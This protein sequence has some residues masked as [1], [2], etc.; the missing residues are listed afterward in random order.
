MRETGITYPDITLLPALAR[1][2]KTDL[3]TLMSFH[4]DLTDIEIENFTGEVDRTVRE[5]GYDV[6]FQM[7]IEKLHEYPTCEKLLY[8]VTFYL[9]SAL[10][11][12]CVSEKEHYKQILEGFYLRMAKSKTAEIRDSALSMLIAYNR[13]REDFSKA[14]EYIK[15]L[16]FST[17]NREEQLAV[18]YTQQEKY[19]K[20]KKMWEYRVLSGVKE[21]QTAL[22]NM[23]DI[24]IKEKRYDDAAFYADK[25]EE[26][27]KQF[28]IAKWIAYT[29]H[30]Q[31]AVEHQD[32]Q[33][34][35]SIL[36]KML[37]AMKEKWKLEESPLYQDMNSND[38]TIFSSQLSK[39]MQNDLING[40]DFAFIREN[41]EFDTF[42]AEW[43]TEKSE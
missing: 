12:Y 30:L 22:M 27:S 33:K 25:Y 11:L 14:E 31:L 42:M 4:D 7:A 29:A 5:Q 6:A 18:L 40:K 36:G 26:I 9:E 43:L 2:L 13:N 16:P 15:A 23:L 38:T 19:E 20:A 3:N 10:F 35:L 39:V 24:A 37:P 32:S 8:C 41:A 34:C 1:L 17:I 28:H 21:I